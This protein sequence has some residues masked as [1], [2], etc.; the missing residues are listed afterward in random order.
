M[1]GGRGV[2]ISKL[3]ALL[4]SDDTVGISALEV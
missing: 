1:L 3:G 4:A 2:Q